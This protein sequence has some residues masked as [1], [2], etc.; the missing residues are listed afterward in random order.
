M[1]RRWC[2]SLTSICWLTVVAVAAM[3]PTIWT[4]APWAGDGMRLELKDAPSGGFVGIVELNGKVYPVELEVDGAALPDERLQGSFDVD[5]YAF[6]VTIHRHDDTTLVVESEGGRFE[7]HPERTTAAPTNPLLGPGRPPG[8]ASGP[9]NTAT[10]WGELQGSGDERVDAERQWTILLYLDGDNNLESAALADLDELESVSGNKAVE[11][12]V[13]LDRAEGFDDSRGNWTGTRLYRVTPDQQEGHIGSDLVLDLGE[14]DMSDPAVLAQ[15]IEAVFT[16]WPAAHRALIMWDHGSG[17]SSH[18]SDIATTAAGGHGHM[19]MPQTR[20]AIAN[21]LKAAGLDRLD[22][23]GF[24]MCLMGELETAAALDGLANVLVY[25]QAIEPAFGWPYNTIMPRFGEGT[26]GARR[27]GQEI[28]QRYGEFYESQGTPGTT[29]SAV[30]VDQAKA[31]QQALSDVV[32]ALQGSVETHWPTMART[33]HYSRGYAPSGDLDRGQAAMASFDLMNIMQRL[34]LAMGDDW[35]A[36]APYHRL[37]SAMD[38]FVIAN[39]V[40]GDDDASHGVAIYAPIRPDM[41]NGNY[42]GAHPQLAAWLAWLQAIHAQQ[43]AQDPEPKVSNVRAQDINGNVVES[44][45]ALGG[46]GLHFTVTGTNIL[47]GIAYSAEETPDGLAVWAMEPFQPA[48]WLARQEGLDEAD[49]ELLT[50]AFQDGDNDIRV[51][52]SGLHLKLRLGDAVYRTTVDQTDDIMP[53]TIAVPCLYEHPSVGQLFC[54]IYFDAD[55]W[56]P[57]GLV[58]FTTADDGSTLV[59]S[60]QPAQDGRVTGLVMLYNLETG[61]EDYASVGEGL[62][63]VGPELLPDF[64]QPGRYTMAFDIETIG[65]A[66]GRS[67]HQI[68]VSRPARVDEMAELTRQY[69]TPENLTGTWRMHE[70]ATFWERRDLVPMDFTMTIEPVKDS[71]LMHM[72]WRGEHQQTGQTL[73]M[74]FMMLPEA[75]LAPI[76]EQWPVLED[77]SMGPLEIYI[78]GFAQGKDGTPVLVLQHPISELIY[79]WVKEDGTS[80]QQ[81]PGGA[82]DGG[83]AGGGAGGAQALQ[84]VWMSSDGETA[85][86]IEGDRYAM[87]FSDGFGGWDVADAGRFQINGRVLIVHSDD[88]EVVQYQYQVSA[89]ELMLSDG[90]EQLVFQRAE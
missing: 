5:G 43:T 30:M 26:M 8:A 89:R 3:A 50:P 61:Q 37:V 73:Q 75:R 88:G 87:A 62:W 36:E 59:N 45:H 55:M 17:W 2:T 78:P 69:F 27:L 14:Q 72:V 20:Q 32:D 63:G 84:G 70:A 80:I 83:L 19:N 60:V 51:P 54:K 7:L 85:M 11:V 64:D 49:V 16:T 47:E 28:V 77:R 9:V 34:R 21:G 35:P 71:P 18:T 53:G 1:T 12:L 25:S 65:G 52:Y 44:M 4:R 42:A 90:Y 6:P 40:T 10:D 76:M 81:G 24:D 46:H 82:P 29:Q 68:D 57:K 39:R 22:L 86:Q 79:V 66:A 41:L 33:I 23:V 56:T 38:E 48:A 31:V 74:E 13:L 67:V 58:A 15:A